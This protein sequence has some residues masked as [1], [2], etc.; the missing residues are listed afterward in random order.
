[1]FDWKLILNPR[2][3]FSFQWNPMARGTAVLMFTV[4]VLFFAAGVLL[5]VLPKKVK[6]VDS[7]LRRALSRG[8]NVCVTTGLLGIFFTFTAF[9][10]AGVLSARFWFLAILLL[11]VSW[12]AFVIWRSNITVPAEREASALRQKFLKYLPRPKKK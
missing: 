6:T 5:W 11:F 9:E 4:F 3:W 8:G 12:G 10:Q 7:P 1:M 2:F